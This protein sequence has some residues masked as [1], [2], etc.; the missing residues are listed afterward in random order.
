[1]PARGYAKILKESEQQSKW[2]EFSSQFQGLA[3]RAKEEPGFVFHVLLQHFPR[4]GEVTTRRATLCGLWSD[5][6]LLRMEF[7]AEDGNGTTVVLLSGGA[8]SEGWRLAPEEKE[9]RRLEGDDFF[10]PLAP[11]IDYS[12]FDAILPFVHWEKISYFGS[13]RVIG[14]PA[15]LFNCFPPEDIQ[16]I[17]PDLKYVR[18]AVDDAYNALLRVE[19]FGNRGLVERKFSVVGFKKVREV[20]IVK[21]IDMVD[22]RSRDKTRLRIKAAAVNQLFGPKTFSR[23]S[24]D[25]PLAVPLQDFDFFD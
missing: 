24:L 22:L 1:M 3:P 15:H 19:F 17:R 21:T 2:R 7:P 18:V 12:S 9:P 23:E 5:R 25:Q 10:A 4:R 16:R 13:G 6:G 20:W 14:R 11:G 8:K